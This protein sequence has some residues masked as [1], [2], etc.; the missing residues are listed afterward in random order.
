MKRSWIAGAAALAAFAAAP[1]L[2]DGHFGLGVKAGTLGLGV[3]GN[4][5]PLPLIDFRFGMNTF[6]YDD[7]RERAGIDYDAT[8]ELQS[9]YATANFKIPASPLRLTAGAFSN[10]NEL[11]LTSA[12]AAS[13]DI[14][15]DT[16][17]AAEVGTIRSKTSFDSTAP[18]LGIGFD[19]SAFGKVGVN[20]D[21][22]VLWQ[23]DPDVSL[24]A[25]GLLAGDPDFLAALDSE[26]QE[27]L[28]DIDDFKAW[29]VVSLGFLYNF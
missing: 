29:P 13:Y 22:G 19:F 26:R 25:D 16:F 15:G 9:F 23:G 10:G 2:A 27:L 4:W 18:Y 12:G 7:D 1:A 11:H 8:L 5:A 24:G 20:L 21:F 3:E 14:G 28:D 17:T 6:D